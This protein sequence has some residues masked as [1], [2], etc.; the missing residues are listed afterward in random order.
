MGMANTFAGGLGTAASGYQ[1]QMNF[2]NWLARQPNY[3]A[4]APQSAPQSGPI[5]MPGYEV[6]YF[7]GTYQ[8]R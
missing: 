6:N 2:N 5:S 7:N 1:N 8:G 3:G 4:N